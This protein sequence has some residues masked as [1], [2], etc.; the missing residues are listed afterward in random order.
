MILE[1]ILIFLVVVLMTA[2]ALLLRDYLRLKTEI[3]ERLDKVEEIAHKDY[4]KPVVEMVE[5]KAIFLFDGENPRLDRWPLK[6]HF[7][8]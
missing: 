4:T 3:R 6:H 8:L 5:E 1:T 2:L 7:R